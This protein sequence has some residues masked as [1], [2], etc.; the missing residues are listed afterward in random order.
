M[1]LGLLSALNFTQTVTDGNNLFSV[2]NYSSVK[3]R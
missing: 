1:L 3:R 2:R